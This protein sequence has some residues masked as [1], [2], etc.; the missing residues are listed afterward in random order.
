MTNEHRHTPADPASPEPSR[1]DRRIRML[2]RMAELGMERLE[3]RCAEDREE[4]EAR[5]RAGQ[6]TGMILTQAQRASRD[7]GEV[8]FQ[9]TTRANRL[10]MALAEKFQ[11]DRSARERQDSVDREA[12]EKQRKARDKAQL[13]RLVKEAIEHDHR[14]ERDDEKDPGDE[15]EGRAEARARARAEDAAYWTKQVSERLTEADVERD[16]GKCPFSALVERLCREMRIE[17]PWEIWQDEDWAQEEAR[18]GIEGSPYARPKGPG[19]AAVVQP[20]GSDSAVGRPE[21]PSG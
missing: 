11:N 3:R 17:P 18:L 7:A 13:E 8:M 2:D 12:D 15:P 19:A 6:V 20:A 9:Q 4:A 5:R 14:A 21:P 16:L 10:C 1:T